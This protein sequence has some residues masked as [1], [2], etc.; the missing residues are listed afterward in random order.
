LGRR[1]SLIEVSAATTAMLALRSSDGTEPPIVEPGLERPLETS[2]TRAISAA[3]ALLR[4]RVVQPAAPG[5]T[6]A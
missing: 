3:W 5:A 6:G 1:P 2:V 4:A